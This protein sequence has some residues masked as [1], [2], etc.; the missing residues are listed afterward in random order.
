LWAKSLLRDVHT[1]LAAKGV[2]FD[3]EMPLGIMLEV[4]AATFM[5]PQLC[6]EADFFSL[7]TNDLAQY[8]FAAAMECANAEQVSALLQS[9]FGCRSRPLLEPDLIITA[10]DSVTK[11]EAIRELVN[12]CYTADRTDKPDTMEDAIWVREEQYSTAIGHGFAVPHCKSDAVLTAS[13]GLLKLREPVDWQSSDG[14]AT[15][16]VILLATPAHDADNQ[17]L[18]IFSQLAR[19]L[20]DDVFRSQLAALDTRDSLLSFLE[21]ELIHHS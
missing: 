21:R 8:W 10:S 9:T 14:T 12:A 13:L 5:L 3:A 6:A 15:S 16:T 20:M 11:E 7:G 19:H 2:A 17:H 1:E 4:P 18:K